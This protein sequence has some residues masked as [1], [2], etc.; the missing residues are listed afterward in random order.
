MSMRDWI[1]DPELSYHVF[2]FDRQPPKIEPYTMLHFILHFLRCS[3]SVTSQIN[4]QVIPEATLNAYGTCVER[5]FS[6]VCVD[7][8]R[9]K[10]P[11]EAELQVSLRNLGVTD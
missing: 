4:P 7:V 10:I 3:P 11:R 5:V 1:L 8:D 2:E 9:F 6:A